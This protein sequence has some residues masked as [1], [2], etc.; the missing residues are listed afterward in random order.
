MQLVTRMRDV[1]TLSFHY[2]YTMVLTEFPSSLLPLLRAIAQSYQKTAVD[3]NILDFNFSLSCLWSVRGETGV[4]IF[5]KWWHHLDGV[6]RSL[7]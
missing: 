1:R 2:I 6:D 7:A 5:Q 3:L 4:L